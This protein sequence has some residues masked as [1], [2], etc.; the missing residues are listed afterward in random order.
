SLIG[1]LNATCRNAM[2]A[3]AGL[4]VNRTNYEVD[5]EHFFLKLT[6]AT[7]TD[8]VRIWR[9][10]DIDQSRLTRDFTRA[11]DRMKTGNARSP[12]LS[13]RILRLL[14]EAWTISSIDY[15]ATQIRSGLVLVA[16]LSTEELARLV[17]DS[18]AEFQKISLETLRKNLLS[19]VAG[20]V[21]D[22]S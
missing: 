10:F 18:S 11:L 2:E 22:V 8:L 13:P 7:N 1:K 14:T 19:L 5:I 21:E 15:G 9:Q 3:A 17:T 20:S 4:C 12:A 6:D 16:L